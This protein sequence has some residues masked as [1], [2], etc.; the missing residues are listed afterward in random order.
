MYEAYKKIYD[1][2]EFHNSEVEFTACK[3]K[4]SNLTELLS[5]TEFHHLYKS[6]H[7]IIVKLKPIFYIVFCTVE[8]FAKRDNI[9]NI[10]SIIDNFQHETLL[11]VDPSTPLIKITNIVSKYRPNVNYMY[12]PSF[13]INPLKHVM[14]AKDIKKIDFNEIQDV[15]YIEP[16]NLP[17]IPF[18]D[19]ECAW[20]RFKPGD[21]IKITNNSIICG[22]EITYRYV[23]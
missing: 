12:G 22:N 7:F 15:I 18:T 17:T 10:E 9:D 14:S 21:V 2:A 8:T 6:N 13:K 16:T 5:D 3:Q 20:M 4:G 1:Y 23:V 19:V 11:V